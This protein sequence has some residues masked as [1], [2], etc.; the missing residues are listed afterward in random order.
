MGELIAAFA[1]VLCIDQ[2][3]KA[4]V[5]EPSDSRLGVV[6][7]RSRGVL[8]GAW[9]LAAG[10]GLLPT[11]ADPV[12]RIGIGVALGGAAGNLLDHLRR[13]AVVDFIDIRVWPV[14]NLADVAIVVGVTAA[15]LTA[16]VGG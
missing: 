9:L 11:F 2:L 16:R 13:G 10:A 7:V 5:A 6:R 14:F 3:S 12:A 4:W 8:I 1:A 15:L